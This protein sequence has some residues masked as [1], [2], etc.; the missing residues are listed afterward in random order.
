[1]HYYS[2]VAIYVVFENGTLT[3]FELQP[4]GN[5]LA[6]VRQMHFPNTSEIGYGEFHVMHKGSRLLFVTD[7]NIFLVTFSN[8]T[9]MDGYHPSSTSFSG[10]VPIGK[11]YLAVAYETL[12]VVFYEMVS[13]WYMK[14][15]GGYAAAFFNRS[16]IS[17]QDIAYDEDS[18]TLLILDG[19]YGVYVCEVHLNPEGHLRMSI[20]PKGVHKR[21][22]YFM[23]LLEG[24]LY[25]A[26]Q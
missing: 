17:V 22:C 7:A 12:G 20:L 1:M 4:N 15:S 13:D 16:S 3:V 23:M 2:S 14:Q 8:I 19:T 21:G 9:I 18:S 11:K 25:L 26:C 6:V 5:Q 10:A 24:E